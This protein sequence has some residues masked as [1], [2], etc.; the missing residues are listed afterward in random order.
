[1]AEKIGFFEAG[2][3]GG[4]YFPKISPRV[5]FIKNLPSLIIQ[6]PQVKNLGLKDKF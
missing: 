6:K 3:P 5:R 4:L 2:L 1:L